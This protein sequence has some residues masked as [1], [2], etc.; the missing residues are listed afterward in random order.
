MDA[1]LSCT[2][3]NVGFTDDFYFPEEINVD[4]IL[5]T[6]DTTA[7]FFADYK[8]ARCEELN[9]SCV[10]AGPNIP[11][12][13]C[14]EKIPVLFEILVEKHPESGECYVSNINFLEFFCQYPKDHKVHYALEVFVIDVDKKIFEIFEYKNNNLLNT[15]I[16]L[17]IPN[18]DE[19][20]CGDE[21][22][23]GMMLK[24]QEANENAL[25]PS[26]KQGFN[27]CQLQ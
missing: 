6:I 9:R 21:E 11:S 26:K 27:R 25:D 18:L 19:N 17:D 8:S 4:E 2:E 7:K 16:K 5:M 12:T 15:Q 23:K 13:S 14:Y 22:T 3:N 24:M 1:I 20:H 10:H